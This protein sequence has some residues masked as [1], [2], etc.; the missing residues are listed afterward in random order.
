MVCLKYFFDAEK[1]VH[2]ISRL[3]HWLSK[4]GRIEAV[5]AAILMLGLYVHSTWL[6]AEESKGFLVAGLFGLMVYILVDG[7]SSALKVGEDRMSNV[8][9]ASAVLFLYL[10]VL[11]ASF[12]FDGVIGAF[13]LTNNLFIIGIGLGVGAMF[14]RSLTVMLVDKG[15][16]TEYRYLEHGAFYA[17]GALAAIMFFGTIVEVPEVVTGLIGAAFIA[18]SFWSSVRYNRANGGQEEVAA[19]VR[20]SGSR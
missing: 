8:H 1:N 15:T 12:S 13:A 18:I 17:I 14:V 20:A 2:W 5:E 10:E 16:L 9:K 19:Q 3:E 6:P 7:V 11:D 4:L